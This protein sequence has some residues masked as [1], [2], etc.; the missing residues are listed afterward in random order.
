MRF[1][2]C[3]GYEALIGHEVQVGSAMYQYCIEN[4]LLGTEPEYVRSFRSNDTGGSNT[5]HAA[6][7]S[8]FL[9]KER[10]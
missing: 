7:D 10:F 4:A 5:M 1:Q 6:H 3:S 8:A 2:R 9:I